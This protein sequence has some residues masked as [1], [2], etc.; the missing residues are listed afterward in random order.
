M[1]IVIINAIGEEQAGNSVEGPSSTKY[2]GIAFE[3][4]LT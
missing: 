3:L 2:A 1:P 4:L